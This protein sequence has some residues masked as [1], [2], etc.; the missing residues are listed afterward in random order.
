[1][2]K[3]F[4]ELH[5][6]YDV[7]MNQILFLFFSTD[8]ISNKVFIYK[9]SMTQEDAHLFVEAMQKEVADHE[10]QKITGL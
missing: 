10:F 4:E 5:E 9:E 7:T 8:V 2:I 6:Y 3:H 1:V